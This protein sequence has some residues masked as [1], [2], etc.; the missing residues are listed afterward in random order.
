MFSRWNALVDATMAG[1]VDLALSLSKTDERQERLLFT[2]AYAN[3]PLILVTRS[4]AGDALD[5]DS[6][7]NARVGILDGVAFEPAV[8]PRIGGKGELVAF[9]A[10][11][12]GLAAVSG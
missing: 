5:F 8:R 1:E 7:S 4:G 3:D 11:A 12:D 6:L 2:D 10:D 9:E